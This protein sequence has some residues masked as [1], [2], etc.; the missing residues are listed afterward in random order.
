MLQTGTSPLR[1]LLYPIPCATGLRDLLY[2][3]PCA[4]GLRDLLYPIS[5]V[6]LIIIYGHCIP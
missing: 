4:T 3:I 1:D 6:Y 2:P 5:L